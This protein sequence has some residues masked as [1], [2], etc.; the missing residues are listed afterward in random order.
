MTAKPDGLRDDRWMRS[1]PNNTIDAGPSKSDAPFTDNASELITARTMRDFALADR[2]GDQGDAGRFGQRRRDHG[3]RRRRQRPGV[4]WPDPRP[5]EPGQNYP[6]GTLLVNY[7]DGTHA[8]AGQA[9]TGGGAGLVPDFVPDLGTGVWPT[10]STETQIA[11]VA[12]GSTAPDGNVNPG[13]NADWWA[14]HPD[15]AAPNGGNWSSVAQLPQ[16]PQGPAG[17]A[18]PSWPVRYVHRIH[19]PSVADAACFRLVRWSVE[20]YTTLDTGD[21][22]ISDGAGGWNPSVSA[23]RRGR[24]ARRDRRVIPVRASWP[25]LAHLPRVTA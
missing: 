12:P 16:G 8:N 7:A 25:V 9:G 21:A 17:P 5:G 14:W 10:G 22:H 23:R 1:G 15:P 20:I 6:P 18:G 13:P 11:I 4:R 3:H 19:G 2:Q 24:S